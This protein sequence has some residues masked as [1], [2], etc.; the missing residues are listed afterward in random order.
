MAILRKLEEELPLMASVSN[1]PDV[2]WDEMSLCSRHKYAEKNGLFASEKLN[3]GP[4]YRV[5]LAVIN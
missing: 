4:F 2:P 3:I 1:M 5:K